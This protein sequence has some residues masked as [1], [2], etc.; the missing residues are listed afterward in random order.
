MTTLKVKQYSRRAV[1][2]SCANSLD[3]IIWEVRTAVED[4]N[5]WPFSIDSYA[6]YDYFF[7]GDVTGKADLDPA[8]YNR[9]DT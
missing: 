5:G 1:D 8:T 7:S 6:S 3:D 2:V 4:D 9:R